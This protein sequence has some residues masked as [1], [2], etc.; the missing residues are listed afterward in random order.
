MRVTDGMLVTN[1]LNNYHNNL[2]KLQKNQNMLSTGKKISRPS[3][4]PV[5]VATS[6]R[7]RTDMARNDAYTKNADYAKSWL[8]ITDSALNQ[9]G[10]LLQRTRELAVQGANGTLTQADMQKMANEIEQLKAQMIQVGNTQ[11]NG[12][13]IFAGFKTTT[14]PFSEDNNSYN[15]DNGLIEFEVGAGG[16]KIA[17][18]VPGDKV[19]DV[20]LTGT[21]QLLVM[22]DNLKSALDSGDH[23]AVS[24]LIVDVDKQMENVLA[25]RA[26]VGAKS[27]RIDLI[28]N[29]LQDDNYNF[30]ALLSKSEDADLAQVITN[31]KMDENVYRASL[32]AGARIMQPSLIDFLR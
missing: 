12:R 8:D 19:F 28:Q 17:V 24:N 31:L 1:F 9:L 14:Q 10:D 2:E 32:A 16:N 20:D 13:Y 6:L 25:V 15:G 4:D 11:Y 29:R 7:I 18:N 5:A 23:Q 30:T 27:N 22:M 3:D 26:E 21:S